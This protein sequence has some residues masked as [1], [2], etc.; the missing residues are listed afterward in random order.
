MSRGAQIVLD[1]CRAALAALDPRAR[2]RDVLAAHGPALD[3]E[4]YVVAIGKASG[5][6]AR[7]ALDALRRSSARIVE[8]CVIAPDGAPVAPAR[9]VRVLRARHPTPDARSVEAAEAALEIAA[10]AGRRRATLLVLVS[11]GASSL[12]A[13]PRRGVTL[14]DKVRLTRALLAS[15]APITEINVVRQRLSRIKGGGLARAAGQARVVTLVL[16]DVLGGGLGLV[17]SGLTAPAGGSLAEARAT[18][19]RVAPD[20]AAR[21]REP[22]PLPHAPELALVGSPEALA[23][24]VAR[25]LARRGVAARVLAQSV[26]EAGALAARYASLA[27]R[28]GPCEAV[29]RAAEPS[30]TLPASTAGRGGRSS[31]LAALV[32]PLLPRGVVFLALATDGVDGASGTGGALLPASL[33][34]RARTALGEAATRFDT[35][36]AHL[37]LG[38][39]LPFG[40]TGHNLCDLH[41]LAR[42]PRG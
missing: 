31:H 28:L 38:T 26:A 42:L 34:V 14:A 5:P 18:V 21:L 16:S 32:A 27:A 3:G 13:A 24:E 17:G 40:P 11:G 36:P 15:G 33:G 12:V 4:V 35:G 30:V 41:V 1:A 19:L 10:R 8:A 39:A 22:A 29:V 6:M 20:L 7:G 23:R 2:T 25:A 9:G 37:A